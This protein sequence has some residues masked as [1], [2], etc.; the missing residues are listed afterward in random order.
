MFQRIRTI[1]VGVA[2][3]DDQDPASSPGGADPVLGP[4]VRLAAGLGAELHAVHAF[5]LPDA[6]LDACA[7]DRPGAGPP[8]RAGYARRLEERLREQVER[9]PGGG[10]V[11]C[12]AMEVEGS[13]GEVLSA[14]AA[15]AGADLLV[16]GA[17]RRGRL[18]SGILGS[19]AERTLV[20]SAVPVL[21]LHHPLARPV[22]RVLLATDLSGADAAVHRRGLDTVEALWGSDRPVVRAVHVVGYDALLPPPAPVPDMEAAALGELDRWVRELAR[23]TPAVEPRVRVGDPAREVVYEASEW[24]ADLLVLGTHTQPD[25]PHRPLGSTSVAVIREASRNVLAVPAAAAVEAPARAPVDVRRLLA[26]V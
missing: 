18:W 14:F 23:A 25:R 15:G 9:F 21:V 13:A 11:R 17:S 12:H 8:A 10:A 6:V 4:A 5:Q 19:T 16:V 2:A 20:E 1:V 24:G 22:R 26:G 7:R 3:V